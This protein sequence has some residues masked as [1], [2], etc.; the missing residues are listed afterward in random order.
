MN[1]KSK[2]FLLSLARQTLVDYFKTGEKIKIDE[3]KLPEKELAKKA[4]T[5]VTLTEKGDLRGCIGN[6]IAKRKMY[7][8]VINNALLAGFG[9]PRFTPL[10]EEEIKKVKIEISILSEAQPY[11]HTSSKELLEMIMTKE[12]GLVVQQEFNQAT[13]LPQVWNDIPDKK[14]FLRALCQKAGLAA[15]A[16][17]SPKTEVFYYTVEKFKE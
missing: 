6:L 5:F 13:F 11:K 4:A 8:D 12:H 2:K 14:E 17:E 7:E 16:W 3:K 10:A 9:D 1:D 15:D